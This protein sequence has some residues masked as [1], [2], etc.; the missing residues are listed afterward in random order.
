MMR[1]KVL[2]L[3]AAA[4]L[5]C[6]LAA[7][8]ALIDNGG[9]TTDT[10]NGHDWLDLTATR[11]VTIADAVAA[12]AGAG[13]RFA[14]DLELSAFL[15]EF[16]IAYDFAPGTF[17]ALNP[18]AASVAQFTSLVGTTVD[19]A[20]L[21]N[22]DVSGGGRFAYLCISA[23]TCVPSSFVNDTNA[24]DGSP[25]LG[26]FLVRDSVSVPAPASLGLLG[27]GLAGVATRRK[28]ASA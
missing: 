14:T 5:A 16:G 15:G 1:M 12:N 28:R 9:Y 8:A 19:D 27:L 2:G 23:G 7:N 22:F 20:A 10:A 6:P 24:F 17:V 25:S 4:A 18:S 11:G 26:V 3:L 13:Y 21:G